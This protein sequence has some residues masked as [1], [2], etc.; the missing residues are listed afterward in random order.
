MLHSAEASSWPPFP[1]GSDELIAW[2]PHRAVLAICDG[3][4]RH[5]DMRGL[6]RWRAT[7]DKPLEDCF[8]GCDWSA[9]GRY[10]VAAQVIRESPASW[11]S[12]ELV[13][14]DV[15]SGAT[16]VLAG[17]DFGWYNW[18]PDCSPTG[19]EVVFL[20]TTL[21]AYPMGPSRLAVMPISGGKPRV[22]LE[23]AGGNFG[24]ASSGARRFAG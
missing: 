23:A 14:I 3:V 18:G 24:W 8:S 17:A 10:L 5:E 20:S 6:S 15:K 16:K 9:N 19:D 13:R 22:L 1:L 4:I 7:P 21:E 11:P 2:H 12:V